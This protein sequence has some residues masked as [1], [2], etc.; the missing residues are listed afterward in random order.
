M[1]PM[2]KLIL[3]LCLG[4][5][6]FTFAAD[7]DEGMKFFKKYLPGKTQKV[8]KLGLTRTLVRTRLG[9]PDT[10]V[11]SQD[12]FR[13]Q[14]KSPNLFLNFNAAKKLESASYQFT[15]APD[16]RKPLKYEAILKSI[17]SMKPIKYKKEQERIIEL[18]DIGIKLTFDDESEVL[19]RIDLSEK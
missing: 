6:H 15:G 7:L 17:E 18:K 10:K 3:I 13:I 1:Q 2:K 4:L 5:S 8:L 19:K 14:S 9:R 12:S 16:L 11:G